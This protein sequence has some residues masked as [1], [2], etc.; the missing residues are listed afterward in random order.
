MLTLHLHG[1]HIIIF[2]TSWLNNK[3]EPPTSSPLLAESPAT[4]REITQ[5]RDMQSI[6]TMISIPEPM[7]TDSDRATESISTPMGIAMRAPSLPTRNTVSEDSPARIRASITV[8]LHPLRTMV[9]RNKARR[10]HLYL[11]QQGR[12]FRMV[13]V[14]EEARTGHLHLR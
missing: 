3:E 2:E 6:P 5:V 4:H 12:I 11:C 8:H 10:G 1:I 7:S 14:R 13:D 9:E